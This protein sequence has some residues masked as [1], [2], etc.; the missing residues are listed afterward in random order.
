MSIDNESRI[1]LIGAGRMGSALAGGWLKAGRSGFIDIVDPSPAATVQSWID[2]GAVRHNPE[3][4]PADILVVAVKP[5][6]FGDLAIEIGRWVGP[7]TLV[8][9]IMAGVSLNTLATKLGTKHVARAMPNTP[10]LV[11]K[12]VTILCPPAGTEPA[13]IE[14]LT[15]LL[16]PLGDVVGPIAEDQILRGFGFSIQKWLYTKFC[17]Y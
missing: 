4:A 14:A 16:S 8:L 5:Q 11:G 1:T 3:P 15:A 9:S 13:R 7:K 12:G 6:V 10:G 2:A 17:S